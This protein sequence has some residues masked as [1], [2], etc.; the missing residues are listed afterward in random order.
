MLRNGECSVSTLVS[1]VGIEAT[2]LSQQLSIMRRS[3]LIRSRKV[4]SSV[5]YSAAQPLLLELLD[6]ATQV[7]TVSLAEILDQLRT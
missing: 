2:Y 5:Y 1:E 4:G 6:T 3:N 7:L